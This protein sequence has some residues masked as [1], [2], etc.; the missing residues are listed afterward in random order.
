MDRQPGHSDRGR[1]AAGRQGS[2]GHHR[3][4]GPARSLLSRADL[5][6]RQRL[7]EELE[8]RYRRPGQGRAGDCRNRGAGPR[9]AIAAGTRRP[10]QPAGQRETV[11]GHAEPPQD[12]DRVE[13]RLDAGNRRAHRRPLQQERGRQFRPGQ[14]RTARG[15]GRLQEDHRAVR[16]RGDLPRHRR[17]RADQCRRRQRPGDVRGFRHQEAARL[18]QRSPELRARRSRSAPRP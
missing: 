2:A 3:S 5:R 12:A 11:R 16:R 8:R 4:A 6:A 7:P 1:G 9:P 17:R 10:R 14:C 18:C 13:F 15:A